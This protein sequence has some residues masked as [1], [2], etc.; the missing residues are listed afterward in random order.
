MLLMR[1]ERDSDPNAMRHLYEVGFET[2]MQRDLVERL[3]GA[4]EWIPALSLVAS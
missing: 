1:R 4:E 2:T 3:R